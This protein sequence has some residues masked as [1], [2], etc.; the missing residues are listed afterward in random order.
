MP[1]L[2]IIIFCWLIYFDISF[3]IYKI[4]LEL[5]FKTF[6]HI[7]FTT[8]QNFMQ[9]YPSLEEIQITTHSPINV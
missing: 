9:I 1:S 8:L 4:S 6:R 7:I 5:L 3:N 2:R